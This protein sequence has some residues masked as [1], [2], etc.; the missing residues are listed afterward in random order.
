MG[1]LVGFQPDLANVDSGRTERSTGDDVTNSAARSR[2]F[3]R[4]LGAKGLAIRTKPAWDRQTIADLR[5]LL[6]P[7][8]RLLDVGCGYG[9]V[10]LPL[11]QLG[12]DV[13]GVDIAPNLLREARRDAVRLGLQLR[14]DEAS[15]TA[16]PYATGSFDVVV[17]LWSAFYELV[18]PAEQV[19]ALSEMCRVLRPTGIGLIEGPI[20][21]APTANDLESGR[22]HGPGRRIV[23]DQ[24]SG[25]EAQ[26]YAH[27]RGSLRRIAAESG[28]ASPSI[29]E[30]DW[31]GRPRQLLTWTAAPPES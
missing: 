8:G 4:R 19:Q 28:L 16:L 12:Y 13:T 30:R 7:A 5:K 6:P 2:E 21:M 29:V 14:F 25:H 15:M 17:S 20:F 10:A 31:G 9:R 22:R 3:Y 26:H 18:E 27:D 23:K 1:E 24:I 11:A